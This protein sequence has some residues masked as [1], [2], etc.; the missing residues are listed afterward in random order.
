M[1]PDNNLEAER[2]QQILDAAE[3][4]FADK[5]FNKARMDDIVDQAG[6]S[7]GALYWY[8]KSKDAL[9]IALIDRVFGG[10]VRQAEALVEAEGAS[11]DRLQTFVQGAFQ[12]IKRFEHLM[13]LG[14]EFLALA[15]RSKVVR[16]KIQEYYRR[17][18]AIIARIVQQ[19][20]DK[21]EFEPIDPDAFATTLIGLVEGFAL[22]FFVD[23][24]YMD[25]DRLREVPLSL[26][27]DGIRMRDL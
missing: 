12:E 17:Y 26:L 16:S 8:Y 19:G 2:R 11:A 3:V 9:I 23:P 10:E 18:S 20:I 13:R 7:K 21:G 1:S 25:L 15:A 5:G 24:E 22:L 14:Y 27:L 4:V 6:L